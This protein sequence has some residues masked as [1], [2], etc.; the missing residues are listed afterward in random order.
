MK[1]IGIINREL[2]DVIS[3]LGHMDEIIICDAGF[4]IP[5]GIK[6]VDISLSENKPTATK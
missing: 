2:S 1:E 3:S 5:L 6:T 4:S